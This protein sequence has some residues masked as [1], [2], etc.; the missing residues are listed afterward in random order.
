M[1]AAVAVRPG[2][3][4]EQR[5]GQ[6]IWGAVWRTLV[7]LVVGAM[8]IGGLAW[9]EEIGDRAVQPDHLAALDVTLGMLALGLM[10]LRRRAPITIAVLLTAFLTVSNLAVGAASIAVVSLATSRRW[11]PIAVVGVLH[12]GAYA[13]YAFVNPYLDDQLLNFVVDV[14]IGGVMNVVLLI[15]IGAYIGLRRDHV[16]SLELRAETAEREQASRVAQAQANERARIAREMHDVLAHRISM[17]AMHAGGLAYRKD[18]PRAEV[19]S[20]AE[21][22][23]DSAHTA[24]SEL[25]EILGVLR[26]LPGAGA[27]V[28]GEDGEEVHRPVPTLAALGDLLAESRSTGVDVVHH[29]ELASRDDPPESIS[30]T[31]YRIVQEGLTNARKHAPGQRVVVTIAGGPGDGLDLTVANRLAPAGSSSAGPAHGVPSSGLGLMGLT[32]RAELGG[33]RVTYGAE[34]GRFLLRAWLP[35][36]E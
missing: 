33:G 1:T 12:V 25:R 23:R 9:Q 16:R 36:T 14:G 24:M 22:I 5:T 8:T 31:A 11:V 28:P 3:P 27:A 2:A 18:L 20:T 10:H 6:R 21:T 4:P 17:V 35:W 32:E 26:D 34:A 29:D 13:V 15:V 7:A 30:R 19:T